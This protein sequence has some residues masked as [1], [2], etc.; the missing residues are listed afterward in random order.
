MHHHVLVLP[1]HSLP[2]MRPGLR[3]PP[4]PSL[5]R[6]M[7]QPRSPPR[8]LLLPLPSVS[9]PHA[10]SEPRIPAQNPAE[11]PPKEKPKLAGPGLLLSDCVSSAPPAPLLSLPGFSGITG[12]ILQARGLGPVVPRT[13]AAHPTAVHSASRAPQCGPPAPGTIFIPLS[14]P[15]FARGRY[16]PFMSASASHRIAW[17]PA[18]DRE[19]C[20][21]ETPLFVN[22]S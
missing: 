21:A 11:R 6:A 2:W 9:S 17:L 16:Q 1:A 18:L 5:P 15:P 8:L 13:W 3:L 12:R 19:R 4:S 7:S 10:K 22:V 20:E 14:G